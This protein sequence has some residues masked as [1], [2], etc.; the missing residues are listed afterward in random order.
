MP[1]SAFEWPLKPVVIVKILLPETVLAEKSAGAEIDEPRLA[2]SGLRTTC[3]PSVH[4]SVPYC[5]VNLGVEADG[6]MVTVKLALAPGASDSVDGVTVTAMPP[7]M[8][9]LA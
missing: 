7:P 5:H 2:C 6:A 9:A 1:L 4:V 3:V 8:A